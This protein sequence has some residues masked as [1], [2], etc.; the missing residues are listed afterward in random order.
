MA[1]GPV[2]EMTSMTN[3]S[4]ATEALVLFLLIHGSALRAQAP[5]ASDDGGAAA[6][7]IRQAAAE[8]VAAFDRGDA[9]AVAAHWLEDGEYVDESGRVFSGRAAIEAEYA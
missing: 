3:R 8:F 9:A 1:A 5:A 4:R 7:A 6:A 2:H